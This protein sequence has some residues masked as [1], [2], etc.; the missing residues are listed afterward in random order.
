MT[1][2]WG[3]GALTLASCRIGVSEPQYSTRRLSSMPGLARPVRRPR[4]SSR[5]TLTAFS[6]RSS[7]SR[8]IS[9]EVMA[10]TRG[11]GCS[12]AVLDERAQGVARDGP[13]DVPFGAEVEDQDRQ[14]ALAAGA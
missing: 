5:K 11:G 2:C 8:R 12:E 9:S 7:A 6:M 1:I 14:P 13:L 3:S 10:V 4:R